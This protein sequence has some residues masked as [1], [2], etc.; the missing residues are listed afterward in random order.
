LGAWWHWWGW[1]SLAL[2]TGVV[3]GVL[4][5]WRLLVLA[6]SDAWAGRHLRAWWQ[7]WTIYAPK[8]PGWL[9]ACGLTITHAAPRP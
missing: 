8:L 3:A 6:S 7:H 2:T 9:H 4:T 1:P 5:G